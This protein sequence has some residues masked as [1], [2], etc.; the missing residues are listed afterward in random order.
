MRRSLET[1][2]SI[3]QSLLGGP[4]P[5][6]IAIGHH[7]L[8]SVSRNEVGGGIAKSQAIKNPVDVNLRGF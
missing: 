3:A 8:R 2:L 5:W 1:L 7:L 4:R 6:P